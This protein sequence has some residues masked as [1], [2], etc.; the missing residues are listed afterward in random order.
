MIFGCDCCD[1]NETLRT[2][3]VSET[4]LRD[5]VGWGTTTVDHGVNYNGNVGGGEVGV[6]GVS[7][8]GGTGMA[9]L[10]SVTICLIEF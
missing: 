5:G 1:G 7:K 9:C 3:S 4:T 2:D 8:Y 6:S 10:R